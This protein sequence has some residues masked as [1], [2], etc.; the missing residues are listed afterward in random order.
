MSG[1]L[2]AL[3]VVTSCLLLNTSL[4]LAV[5]AGVPDPRTTIL[6]GVWGY[7]PAPDDPADPFPRFTGSGTPDWF[8]ANYRALK[9]NYYS[10]DSIKAAGIDM[11][12]TPLGVNLQNE[13]HCFA[14]V[15]A[16][17][18]ARL[19]CLPLHPDVY[20]QRE[21][22][23]LD[24]ARVRR[25][26]S[27]PVWATSENSS[28]IGWYIWD[29][30]QNDREVDKALRLDSLLR[31][32][33]TEIG[34]LAGKDWLTFLGW[35][36]W[37]D[38][39]RIARILRGIGTTGAGGPAVIGHEAFRFMNPDT[40]ENPHIYPVDWL[41]ASL[42]RFYRTVRDNAPGTPWWS[43]THVT[44]E[45]GMGG[46]CVWY[47]YGVIDE[48][49]LRMD[50][51]TR[52]GWGAKGIVY[53][54]YSHYIDA[55]VLP[56]YENCRPTGRTRVYD[57]RY[58]G[59][60][61]ADR[62]HTHQYARFPGVFTS[63]W[64]SE[65]MSYRPTGFGAIYRHIRA[66]NADVARIRPYLGPAEIFHPVMSEPPAVGGPYPTRSFFV[67]GVSAW[68]P[69]SVM[70]PFKSGWGE[71]D[72]AA[73]LVTPLRNGRDYYLLIVNQN[74]RYRE[75]TVFESI[76]TGEAGASAFVTVRINAE[77]IGGGGGYVAK[78]LVT[79]SITKRLIPSGHFVTLF[80][81][82]DTGEFRMYQ[83]VKDASSHVGRLR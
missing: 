65:T 67:Y 37:N 58:W 21:S 20:G 11:I 82:L 14:T 12:M 18:A 27:N 76:R 63:E 25:A 17:N 69:D 28:V 3:S 73:V 64:S 1:H 62:H 4:P 48:A 5:R 8:V 56:D 42:A 33:L 36:V 79:D 6:V 10:Y 43:V 70:R 74:I 50:V 66:V 55:I 47:P 54:T 34:P 53:L 29:E 75:G 60:D 38:S 61:W 15:R 16:A 68:E 30:P 19:F 26:L 80:D 23:H 72:K 35:F 83:I 45:F 77:L 78:N 24:V 51:F 52:L 22:D 2:K 46:P 9:V 40:A 32:Q 49:S 44:D 31:A 13:G 59:A 39:L 57:G 81:T 7:P 41:N 71:R